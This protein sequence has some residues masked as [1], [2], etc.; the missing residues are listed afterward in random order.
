[1]RHLLIQRFPALYTLRQSQELIQ[2][3]HRARMIQFFN[4]SFS[5]CLFAS[6]PILLQLP[7]VSLSSR[8][9]RLRFR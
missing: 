5:F 1:M 3:S 9:R 7:E 6:W 4:S 8:L 2:V